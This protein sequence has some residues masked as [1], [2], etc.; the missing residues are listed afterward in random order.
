MPAYWS[1]GVAACLSFDAPARDILSAVHLAADGKQMLLSAPNDSLQAAHV[2]GMAS[3][4]P[5]E[6]DV[7]RRLSLGES[8]A[9]I[10][11]KLH[12]ST[13]TVRT[14]VKHILGKLRVETRRDLIDIPLPQDQDVAPPIKITRFLTQRSPDG[15]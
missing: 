9:E 7:L 13:E 4:T 11:R 2:G 1:S 3:L 12:V 15:G 5:R 8:N 14:H 10:A 6:R